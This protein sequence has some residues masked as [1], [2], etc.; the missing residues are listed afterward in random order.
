MQ[1]LFAFITILFTFAHCRPEGFTA[2]TSH[3]LIQSS[4]IV[5]KNMDVGTCAN[6]T[7]KIN[8]SHSIH[9]K[10]LVKLKWALPQ[11]MVLG[12]C[13][14]VAS[15]EGGSPFTVTLLGPSKD[16]KGQV[17]SICTI[18]E[19][20]GASLVTSNA[21]T[22]ASLTSPMPPPPPPP[23]ACNQTQFQDPHKCPPYC[24]WVTPSTSESGGRCTDDTPIECGYPGEVPGG[25][26]N[27]PV[28][29]NL[30]LDEDLR[31]A[32]GGD[33]NTAFNWSAGTI[34]GNTGPIVMP[35]QVIKPG[36]SIWFSFKDGFSPN[37]TAKG[38]WNVCGWQACVQ[39]TAFNPTSTQTS[40][41]S[42]AFETCF[43][44]AGGSLD[45]TRGRAPNNTFD[46]TGSN[47]VSRRSP[48]TLY[49]RVFLA[50]CPHGTKC[51]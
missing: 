34:Q 23:P 1:T 33:I 26:P 13:C 36:Q 31:S 9:G 43:S 10:E 6:T 29:V 28:C 45:F 20:T 44:C 42:A 15:S 18:Y 19:A 21:T 38:G 48:P 27:A 41:Q 14:S 35:P 22:Y 2:Y 12:Q 8:K 49:A 4:T 32:V 39:Y 16:H 25:K 24:A 3:A 50:K 5:S 46:F 47:W 7:K 51:E 40:V 11:E 30:I 37:A 17:E